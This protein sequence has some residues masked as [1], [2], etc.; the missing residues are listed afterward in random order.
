MSNIIQIKRGNGAP[1]NGALKIGELGLDLNTNTLYV[2][3]ATDQSPSAAAVIPF[4]KVA[5]SSFGSQTANYVLAAPNGSNGTP[6][7]RALVAADI[8][9]LAASKITSGTL[10]ITQGGTGAATAAINTVFAGPGSGSTAAPSFRALVAADIPNLN[11]SK[12]TAGT[13]TVA[14]GGT[15]Q[16]SI[17]NIQAGKDGN[18]DTISSTYL[19]LNGGTMT[20]T[21]TMQ[22]SQYADDY[23][24]ALNMNNSNIYGV[25]S[26]YTSDDAGSATEGISFYRTATTVDTIHAH[27]GVLYFTPN[28]TLGTSGTSYKVYHAGNLT[29]GTADP[30]GGANGDIYIK[31]S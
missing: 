28:R 13:L 15:G 2:G 23:T 30:S 22:A 8:P 19:K 18:G 4:A 6:S 1:S 3:Q 12:I 16:T 29:Y 11:A 14:R 24:G 9:N 25:N 31:Y 17:A 26:I 7:F 5:L 10:A 21:L 20:G 27:S